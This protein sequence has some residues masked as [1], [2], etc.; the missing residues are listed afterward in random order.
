MSQAGLSQL[1]G[2]TPGGVKMVVVSSGQLAQTTSK[3]ITISMPGSQKTVTLSASGGQKA[4]GQ[5][6]QTSSGQII[7]LPAGGLMSGGKPV[8]VQMAG[9]GQKT[10][11]L[12]Q[13]PQNIQTTKVQQTA[14]LTDVTDEMIQ[15]P[16]GPG[17]DSP[18]QN[19]ESIKIEEHNPPQLDGGITTP[20]NE[21]ED[22]S[23]FGM[24]FS[25]VDGGNDDD[26]KI[27][28]KLL[29]KQELEPNAASSSNDTSTVFVKE[30]TPD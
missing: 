25:Q 3:P 29:S 1:S 20:P 30:E 15:M 7:Q 6:V 9:G 16:S 22:I 26:E 11:T 8:T 18:A 28:D 2:G 10:L 19:A 27:P 14:S 4:G 17:G 13:A 5:I 21:L 12:V 23:E 24:F